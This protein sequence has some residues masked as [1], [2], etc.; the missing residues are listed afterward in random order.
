[1]KKFILA[2]ILFGLLL[3]S[4]NANSRQIH[5]VDLSDLEIYQ[6]FRMA[7]SENSVFIL[8]KASHKIF[9]LEQGKIIKQFGRKGQGPGEYATPTN[10]GIYDNK[11]W[12][13]NLTGEL[14]LFDSNGSF[15]TKKRSPLGQLQFK[16]LRTILDENRQIAINLEFSAKGGLCKQYIYK[17]RN[18]EIILAELKIAINNSL[19]KMIDLRD[20][21]EPKISI[22]KNFCFV[23]ADNTKYK[24]RF[25]DLI[26]EK[27]HRMAE[28]F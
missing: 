19:Q 14:I 18:K 27:F 26:S 10:I 5:S 8:D 7:V 3:V 13:M 6:P 24:I 16:S 22:G 28:Q 25:F 21:S 11:L 4:S 17:N 23:V 15:L 1:M 2:Q 20:F 12:V 9:K